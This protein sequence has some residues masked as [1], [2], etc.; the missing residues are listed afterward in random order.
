MV[1]PQGSGFLLFMAKKD[2]ASNVKHSRLP[3]YQNKINE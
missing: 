1:L 3:I 2:A